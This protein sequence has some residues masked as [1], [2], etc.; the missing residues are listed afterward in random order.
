VV[1]DSIDDD[2]LALQERKT[3]EIDMAM[4]AKN[5]PGAMTTR[6]LLRL[7]G[8]IGLSEDAEDDDIVADPFIFV[9]DEDGDDDVSDGEAPTRVPLPQFD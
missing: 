4:A 2:I 5:R 3:T 1:K 9:E 8:P 6:E 7:F